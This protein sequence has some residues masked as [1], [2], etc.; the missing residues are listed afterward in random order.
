MW[1]RGVEPHSLICFVPI[2]LYSYPKSMRILLLL[3][4]KKYECTSF[5]MSLKM[6]RKKNNKKRGLTNIIV[7]F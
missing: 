7:S 6:A 3:N 2:K 5:T 4:C 1:T